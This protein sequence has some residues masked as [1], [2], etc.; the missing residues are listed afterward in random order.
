L[1]TTNTDYSYKNDDDDGWLVEKQTITNAGGFCSAHSGVWGG[2]NDFQIVHLD[3][4]SM[5]PHIM[6]QYKLQPYAV[7]E[8]PSYIC[9]V[10]PLREEQG[11]GYKCMLKVNANVKIIS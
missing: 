11:T 6:L 3:I 10:C 4:I 8:N 1:L 5:Y 7:I 2:C 9:R